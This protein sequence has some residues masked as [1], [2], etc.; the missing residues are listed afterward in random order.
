M[1]FVLVLFQQLKKAFVLKSMFLKLCIF[2]FWG[3][4][5]LF[6]LINASA[7]LEREKPRVPLEYN[8]LIIIFS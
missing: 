7:I 4:V 6:F 1:A 2:V 5:L 8:F 3:A